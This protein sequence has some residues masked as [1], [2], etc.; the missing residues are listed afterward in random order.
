MKITV[1]K[2]SLDFALAVIEFSEILELKKKYVI[3]K[4]LLKSGTSIGANIKEAQNPE[5][6]AD[7]IHKM[8]I[9][10]KEISETEYWLQLCKHSKTYPYNQKLTEQ[11]STIAKITT[12]KIYKSKNNLKK[13]HE[14]KFP[15]SKSSH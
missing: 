15:I 7:F 13:I 9:A 2:L 3:S 4:Q 12:K 11:L 1:V 14:P 5:S 10:S 6:L 8:K